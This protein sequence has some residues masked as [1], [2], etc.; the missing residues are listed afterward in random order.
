MPTPAKVWNL[1]LSMLSDKHLKAK[2]A[3]THGLLAF[4]FEMLQK[5]EHQLSTSGSEQDQ[6]FFELLK[7]AGQSALA[8]DAVLARHG[9]QIDEGAAEE[10]LMHYNRFIV[11]CNRAG[12]PILPKAHLMYHCIQ[13]SLEQGNPRTYTT[14]VD[15]SYNG[16]IARVCRS[17]HRRGWAW[18]VYRKL[19]ILETVRAASQTSDGMDC[20]GGTV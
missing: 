5:Y 17:V 15:E 10:M 2:A 8:F 12:L 13:R 20:S 18:A 3:E 7:H 1:T 6:L 16:A 14:Y 4:V 19:Q 9:R 11:L